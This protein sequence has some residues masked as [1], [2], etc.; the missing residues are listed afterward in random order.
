MDSTPP[1]NDEEFRESCKRIQTFKEAQRLVNA[2]AAVENKRRGL[3][4]PKKKPNGTTMFIFGVF[5][6]SC[7]LVIAWLFGYIILD[8]GRELGKLFGIR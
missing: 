7:S 2:Y 5:A 6:L 8:L 4:P 1:R 3:G